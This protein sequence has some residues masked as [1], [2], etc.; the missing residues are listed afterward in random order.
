MSA[1]GPRINL[2]SDKLMPQRDLLLNDVEVARRLSSRLGASGPLAIDS[3]ARLRTKYRVGDSLRVLHRIRVGESEFIVAARTFTHGAS[4]RAY[5]RAIGVAVNCHPLLPVVHDADLDTVFWTFPNDRRIKGLQALTNIPAELARLFVP[6]WTRSRVVA[7]APEK[8][9]TAQCLDDESNV[10]AYAK[11]YQGDEG[12]RIFNIYEALRRSASSAATGL[13]LPLAIAYGEAHR[14]L[15]L[16]PIEGERIDDLRG[17]DMPQGYEKLGAAL[18]ALHSLPLPEG[19]PP[20]ERLGAER[21]QRAA[22]II[23]QAR[24]DVLSEAHGLADELAARFESK[25]DAPVCLHGDVHP[26]NGILRGDGLALID[27]DQA[28]SG[29]AANDLGSL[30]ASL[31]YKHLSGLLRRARAQSLGDAFLNGYASVRKLPQASQLRWHAAA[32]L[33]SERALRAVNRVRPEGLDCLHELLI[34]AGRIL[35]AGGAR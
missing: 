8:C 26:K 19:L 17:L 13:R 9:A 12:R 3:C 10:L 24:P 34:E 30:L 31:S 14:M 5:E 20:S 6:A 22:H 28:A 1:N 18:A 4:R 7:Y 32:A 21:L 29:D 15:L 11:V 33:L 16:E 35:R 23:G 2:A 25:G 27:L